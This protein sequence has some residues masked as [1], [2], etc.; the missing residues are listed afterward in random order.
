MIKI[1]IH[2]VLMTSKRF[3][4]VLGEILLHNS[5]YTRKLIITLYMYRS[6]R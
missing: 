3:K 5:Y 1:I 2:L 4:S 6:Y